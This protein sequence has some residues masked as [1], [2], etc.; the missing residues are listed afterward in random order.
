MPVGHPDPHQ[1]SHW[2]P[3]A[4]GS[5]HPTPSTQNYMPKPKGTLI[6]LDKPIWVVHAKPQFILS[7]HVDLP[8]DSYS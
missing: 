6:A 5:A 1:A 3:D 7:I 2:L 4:K 8:A